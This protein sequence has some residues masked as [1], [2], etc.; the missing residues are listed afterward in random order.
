MKEAIFSILGGGLVLVALIDAV[1]ALVRWILDRKAHKEDRAE[2]KAERKTEERLA[3]LEGRVAEIEE[4]TGKFAQSLDLQRET[5]V[6]ILY[7]RIRYLAK[8]YIKDGEISFED[9]DSL[10]Q[11]HSVYHRNGGN[12]NLDNVMK[13][14]NEL[15]LKKG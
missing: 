7:D 9:R 14:A 15:P 1:R 4:Q 11:M 6:Y 13:L 3:R 12:G 2:E 5:N 8:C 10:N